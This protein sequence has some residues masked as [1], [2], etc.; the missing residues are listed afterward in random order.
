MRCITYSG[1]ERSLLFYKMV[2]QVV[3]QLVC[4]TH[5]VLV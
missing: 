1:L 5:F 4:D 3:E 2:L